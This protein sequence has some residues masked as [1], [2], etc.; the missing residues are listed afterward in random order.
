V[1]RKSR[2]IAAALMV[3]LLLVF[4][5]SGVIAFYSDGAISAVVLDDDTSEP[6]A[7]AVVLAHWEIQTLGFHGPMCVAQVQISEATTD[8]EGRFEIPAWSGIRLSRCVFADRVKPAELFVFKR[9]YEHWKGTTGDFQRQPIKIAR[10][11]VEQQ[12]YAA[13]LSQL[14]SDLD[15]AVMEDCQWVH[16]PLMLR[17][18]DRQNEDFIAHGYRD[19]NAPQGLLIVES[20]GSRCGTAVERFVQEYNR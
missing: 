12:A 4:L 1:K 3:A 7:G 17:E 11:R 9:G 10:P 19:F 16:A 5:T 8:A 2:I 6:I 18:L 15:H 14:I 13:T 20:E